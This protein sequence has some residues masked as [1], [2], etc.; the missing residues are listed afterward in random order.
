MRC[1]IIWFL[2][3]NLK[4]SKSQ[5]NK[6]KSAIKNE[7]EVILRLSSNM[8]SNS[9]D[10][11]NFPHKSWSTNRQLPNFHKV[12]V[13]NLLANIKLRKS[14]LCKI[15]QLRGFLDRFLGS[16]QKT[17]LPIMKNVLQPLAKSFL[18]PLGLETAGSAADA[19]IHKKNLKL[20]SYSTNNIKWRNGRHYGS[21]LLKSL[22]DYCLLIKA[23][24][25]QL[26]MKKKTTKRTKEQKGGFLGVLLGTL[27]A[28]LLENMLTIQ[29]VNGIPF[30][31]AGDGIIRFGY[32]PKGSL[33]EKNFYCCL[34][35]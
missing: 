10:E 19:G 14:Q 13:N 35:L 26:K 8:I 32:G 2:F 7:R 20:R 11:T 6:V 5:V 23:L 24:A 17:G 29:T 25:K 28:I 16:L 33:K 34:I 22:K 30:K 18:M 3:N 31:R 4:L 12:F 27:G 9:D 15:I 21:S 1:T